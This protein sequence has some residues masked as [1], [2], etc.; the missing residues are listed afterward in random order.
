M[1]A[2]LGLPAATAIDVLDRLVDRS[3]VSVDPTAEG[4]LRYRLLDS[5]R[6]V[7]LEQLAASRS[8]C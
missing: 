5:V 6:A 2:A 8:R 1:L 7:S 3:L 4:A